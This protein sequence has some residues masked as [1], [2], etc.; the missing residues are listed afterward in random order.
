MVQSLFLFP[1]LFA[2]Q[3]LSQN[4][5]APAS[6]ASLYGLSTSTTLPFPAATQSNSS[7]QSFISSKWGLSKGR[8]QNGGANLAFVAD[9]FP[10]APAPGSGSSST[11]SSNASAPV[12]QVQYPAGSFQ[13]NS[14]G[15]AQFYAMWNAS[16]GAFQSMLL[17]YEDAF[18]SGFDWVKGGKLP[19]LR[20][21]PDPNNCLG[22][23]QA[24]R[25]NCFS[26]RV[27]W[28]TDGAGEGELVLSLC[29]RGV[30]PV[31][32]HAVLFAKYMRMSQGLMASA[33]TRKYSAM[34]NSESA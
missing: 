30:V 2:V 32:S 8:I 12:L 18:D 10:N 20:G 4:T 25:T 9:P 21:G 31:G 22:G 17:S 5:T 14:V 6:V 11:S 15:G 7:T 19:G 23:N 29:G 13:D 3:A 24:N 16:G 34:T 27:M 33:T 28:R 26:S 1:A